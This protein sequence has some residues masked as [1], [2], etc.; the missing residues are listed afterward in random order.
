MDTY[1]SEV[2]KINY[3][4]EDVYALVS[5]LSNLESFKGK[6]PANKISNLYFDADTCS[7]SMSPFGELGVKVVE[8]EPNKTV[9]YASHHSPIDFNLWLQL[10]QVDTNDTRMKLTFKAELNP[11]VKMMV[12]SQIQPLL[13][14]LADALAVLPYNRIKK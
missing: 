4:A 14:K 10:K 11:I 2:K 13:N 6:I 12:S 8:R 5:D 7:F 9:K 1:E 3:N